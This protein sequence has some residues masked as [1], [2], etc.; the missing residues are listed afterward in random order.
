VKWKNELN[1]FAR[2]EEQEPAI[3][4]LLAYGGYLYAGGEFIT[5]NGVEVNNIARLKLK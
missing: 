5:I 4:S 2:Q 3:R 1:S